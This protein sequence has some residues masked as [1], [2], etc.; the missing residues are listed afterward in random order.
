MD[1]LGVEGWTERCHVKNVHTIARAA[2]P[3][4]LI[5]RMAEDTGYARMGHLRR[6]FFSGSGPLA[7]LRSPAFVLF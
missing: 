2:N 5:V 7:P 3:S 4:V 1:V 6:L